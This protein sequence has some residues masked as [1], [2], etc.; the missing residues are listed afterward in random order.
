MHRLTARAKCDLHG[1]LRA[2][3]FVFGKTSS[4][5][6]GITSL[7]S[8]KFHKFA[9]ANLWSQFPPADKGR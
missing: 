4:A 5:L 8:A 7:K 6:V 3:R 1:G 2:V 9:S